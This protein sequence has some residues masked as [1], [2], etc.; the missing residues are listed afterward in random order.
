MASKVHSYQP[1]S[2]SDDISSSGS[3]EDTYCSD[4]KLYNQPRAPKTWSRWGFVLL[5]ASSVVLNLLL[6]ALTATK[7]TK[8]PTDQDC[9][10]QLS[11]YSPAM[12]AVE[13]VEYDFAAEFN[14]TNKYRGLPTPEREDAWFNLTYKHAVEIPATEIAGLNRSESD[15]LKHVPEDVGTGYVAILEVFHQLHCLNMI[16]MFTWYQAGKY[17]G[18]PDGLTDK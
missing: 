6:M 16:R 12:E 8:R 10:K 17:P 9:A 15:N 11:V 4:E 5:L 2:S 7:L 14:S 1:V 18:I 13:Y 3:T